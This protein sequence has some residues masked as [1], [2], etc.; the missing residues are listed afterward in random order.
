MRKSAYRPATLDLAEKGNGTDSD[1]EGEE[2]QLHYE[3]AAF[4]PGEASIV[5]TD[6][7]GMDLED[8]GEE[9]FSIP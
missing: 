9:I 1:E 7:I 3:A 2:M 4:Q 8:E 5:E 6:D